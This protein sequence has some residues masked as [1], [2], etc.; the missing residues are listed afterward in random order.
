MDRHFR[1]PINAVHFRQRV[2]RTLDYAALG[3]FAAALVALVSPFLAIAFF[4]VSIIIGLFR[5]H[6]VSASSRLIDR[7]YHLKDRILTAF[8]LLRRT[9]RTPMEQ[10]QVDDAAEHLATVQ[11]QAVVPIRLPK[12]FWI[13]AGV[14]AMDYAAVALVH[15]NFFRSGKTESVLQTLPIENE[16]L[17]EEIVAKTEELAQKHSGEQSLQN[18]SEQLEMFMNK[19]EFAN[20]DV[21]ESLMTLSEMDEAFQAALDSMKLEMM[22]ELL[23]DLAKTLEL[24]E[25]TVPI[26]TA[27][28][29]GDYSQAAW[30]LKKMDAESLESLSKPERAAMAEQMQIIADKAE[31]QNQKPLQEAAQNMSDALKDDDGEAGKSAADSLADEVEKHGIRQSIGKDLGNKQM[32]LGM[33]KAESGLGMS[34]GKGTEKSKTGSET[35]GSGTAGDPNSGQETSLQGQRQQQ[36]LT[37]TLGEQGDSLTET[38]DSQEMTTAKSQ[39]D[40]REQFLRYQKIS[41][42]VLDAEPIPLGQRQVIRRYFESIRPSAE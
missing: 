16:A 7:H 33:M 20:M 14:L 11:P 40:Y 13:A 10:L 39:R 30:E 6:T 29:K 41:E 28:E 27:L 1:R 34:G 37:G 5:P 26:S 4:C 31:K 36:T 35:W 18:L 19:F 8:A 9:S 17:L 22:E 2:Q 21:K 15:N 24:A 42:S 25:K 3:T 32:M 38:I 12:M 23:Q